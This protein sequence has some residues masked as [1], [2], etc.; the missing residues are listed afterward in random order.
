MTSIKMKVK[1]MT[2]SEQPEK[3]FLGRHLSGAVN[4]Q[5]GGGREHYGLTVNSYIEQQLKK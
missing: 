2:C 1:F 5:A 4:L 3:Y